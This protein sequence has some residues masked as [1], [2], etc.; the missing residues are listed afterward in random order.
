MDEELIS[1]TM[2]AL[3]ILKELYKALSLGVGLSY[4]R[5][6]MLDGAERVTRLLVPLEQCMK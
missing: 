1:E 6:E 4:D 3:T 5:G 2:A